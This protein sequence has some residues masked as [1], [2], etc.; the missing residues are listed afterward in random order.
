MLQVITSSLSKHLIHM[1]FHTGCSMT[2]SL[3]CVP[4]QLFDSYVG[5]NISR[6]N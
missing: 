6:N 2:F 1:F 5:E 4:T 3:L